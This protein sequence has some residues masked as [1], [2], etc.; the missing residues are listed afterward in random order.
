MKTLIT[1]LL[2]MTVSL[3]A[4]G[5]APAVR[6]T[7]EGLPLP[8]PF[9]WAKECPVDWQAM[10]GRYLLS[11]SAKEEQIDLKISVITNYGFRLVRMS[12]FSKTGELLADGFNFVSLNQRMLRMNLVPQNDDEQPMTALIKLYYSDWSLGCAKDRLV[13]ILSLER[14]NSTSGKT[15]HYRLVRVPVDNE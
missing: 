10:Q 5:V 1:I 12:R 15:N 8:W 6:P 3:S 9:P 11:D 13:P 4:F 7:S 2:G 14:T